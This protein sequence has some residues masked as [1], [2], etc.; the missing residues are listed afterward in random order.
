MHH[1]GQVFLYR[2][3]GN[4]LLTSIIYQGTIV[5]MNNHIHIMNKKWN[6]VFS[7]GYILVSADMQILVSSRDISMYILV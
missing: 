6:P 2:I 5:S 3:W 4:L 7:T 1:L